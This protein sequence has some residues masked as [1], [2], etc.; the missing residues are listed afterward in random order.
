MDHQLRSVAANATRFD[1]AKHGARKLVVEDDLVSA[2]EYG[3]LS[4]AAADVAAEEPLSPSS[5][6]WDLP[7]MIITPHVAGQEFATD[8]QYDEL[9]L[10]TYV[11]LRRS[12][13]AKPC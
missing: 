12:T 7:N 6:L 8:R 5:K 10:T 9:F 2:L 3:P 13:A 1:F 11:L 4:A